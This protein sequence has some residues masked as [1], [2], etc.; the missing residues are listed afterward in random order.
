[1]GD[2]APDRTDALDRAREA[3]ERRAWG[4]AYAV[5]LA[6]HRAAPLEPADL[7]RLA[8]VAHLVGR[9]AES[10][11][12]LAAAHQEYLR[13]GD[14]EG[15]ARCAFWLGYALQFQGEPARGGGW[16]ARARRLLDEA[17]EGPECA[18]RGYL[19]LPDGVRRLLEGDGD[20]AYDTFRRALEVG[21]RCGDAALVTLARQG[22]GRTLVRAGRVDEG[23]ALLDEVMV[24]VTADE[25]PPDIVG[26]IYCSV[27]DACHEVCDLRRAREW[28]AALSAWCASQPDLVAHRGVCLVRRAELLQLHGAW[29]DAL[30]E[31]T[32]AC[33]RVGNLPG[34]A[35]GGAFYQCGELHRLRGEFARAEQAYREAS[36]QGRAPQPGLALLR[37]AQGECEAA[38]AAIASALDEARDLQTRARV[39][40]ASVEIHLAAGQ[41]APAREGADALAAIAAGVPSPFLRAL[42]AH[43]AGAVLLAEGEP[44]AAAAALRDALACWREL[45]APYEAARVGALLGRAHRALGDEDAARM[46][47]DAARE[48]FQRL[49][50]APELARLQPPRERAGGGGGKG[51]RG[52]P[53]TARELE[54]LRQLATGRTNRAIADALAI[55]ERTVA[56]HVAN[57]F[58]KLALSSRAAATAWAY[59]HALV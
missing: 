35:A 33:D 26:Q 37:L 1:M 49:G 28:T 13:H 52:A 27:L 15:A 39:L 50:A 51:A 19:L 9:D 47:L 56:R 46:E 54:V 17:G 32:R 53:L 57:I 58:S 14:A 45:D 18:L 34:N 43:A 25:L 24:A 42:A 4:E 3:F 22:Q 16:L 30:E 55:S 23:M 10:L 59:Q 7:E 5:L 21:E 44:R 12:H 48:V 31:A 40:G 20:G 2:G 29:P 41:V 38:A 36:R 8:R 6:A 11:D